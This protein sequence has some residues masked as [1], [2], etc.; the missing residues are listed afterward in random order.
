MRE[1]VRK[2]AG[3]DS[4]GA[5]VGAGAGA[6]AGA[7]MS[8]VIEDVRRAAMPWIRK[9]KLRALALLV[10]FALATV[11]VLA[12]TTLPAWP[13]I[14]AALA[15]VAV[16][17]N[18]TASRLDHPTCLGCGVNLSA[19]PMG[20]HG[21]ACPQCGCLSMTGRSDTMVATVSNVRG[22]GAGQ[23]LSAKVAK[24][25]QDRRGSRA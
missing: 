12:F 10:A 7:G 13:V 17:V 5:E 22:S 15:C 14:G 1:D 8:G 18:K 23:A 4:A 24:S 9:A 21:R 2:G 6:A 20:E 16:G 11:G 25:S 3:G 19:V